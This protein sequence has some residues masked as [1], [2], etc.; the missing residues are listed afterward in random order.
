MNIIRFPNCFLQ[1]WGSV[2]DRLSPL[3]SWYQWA[4]FPQADPHKTQVG[5]NLR[6]EPLICW[7]GC[8]PIVCN[9]P[10]LDL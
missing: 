3:C 4:D 8:T 6:P 2:Q 5:G 1:R 10:C 7:N 9:L